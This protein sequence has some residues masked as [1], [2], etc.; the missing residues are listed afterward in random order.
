MGGSG[1]W[2]GTKA[3]IL[4]ALVCVNAPACAADGGFG[5]PGHLSGSFSLASDYLFGGFT[6]TRHRPVP[7]GSLDWDTGTGV[8]LQTFVS[9]VY[10]NDRR[11]AEV[12]LQGRYHAEV[13]NFSADAAFIYFW[14]P[15]GPSSA[16]HDFWVVY[17]QFAYDFGFAKLTTNAYFPDTFGRIRESAYVIGSFKVPV[18]PRFDLRIDSGHFIRPGLKN[19]TDWNAGG[20]WKIPGWFDLDLRYY[21]S[22]AEFAGDLAEDRLIVKV[23]RSF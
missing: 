8:H 14:Y 23:T 19:V 3:C 13:G 10:F 22:D 18:T 15:G 17:G 16:N 20:T 12:D 21:G 6:Q 5:L 1:V 11:E 7:Q 4:A 2:R 9:R